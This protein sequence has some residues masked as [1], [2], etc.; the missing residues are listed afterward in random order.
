MIITNFYFWQLFDEFSCYVKTQ[1]SFS[2]D[3]SVSNFNA[4][5]LI[6]ILDQVRGN[7]ANACEQKWKGKC[8]NFTKCLQICAVFSFYCFFFQRV[9]QYLVW[10]PVSNYPDKCDWN[11]NNKEGWENFNKEMNTGEEE[12]RNKEYPD[13]E[14][15]V[16]EIMKKQ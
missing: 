9:C 13:L 11:L 10:P 4:W 1:L 16:I 3:F 7:M 5:I 14:K 8:I 15:E 12:L 2:L 6:K